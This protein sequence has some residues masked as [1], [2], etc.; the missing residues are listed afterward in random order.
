M[1]MYVKEKR[2]KELRELY[3]NL[4]WILV[5]FFFFSPLT[6]ILLTGRN[7]QHFDVNHFKSVE[8]IKM[9]I[10]YKNHMLIHEGQ[11][12]DKK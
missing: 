8:D 5:S 11:S 4:Y 6:G 10:S 7:S 1:V 3:L 9:G 2:T 12:Q